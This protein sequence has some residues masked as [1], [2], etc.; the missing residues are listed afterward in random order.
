MLSL[1]R[2]KS[3]ESG[4]ISFR[5]VLET[6]PVAVMT[7]RIEDFMI[8]YVNAKSFE[9]IREIEHVLPITADQL[10]GA[11]IDV[12]HKDPSHQRMLLSNPRN[13]P[14]QAQITIGGE[15]LDLH[16]DALHDHNNNYTHAVLSW[17]VITGKV[18]TEKETRRLLQMV[19]KMPLNVMTCD[20]HDDFKINYVNQTSLDTLKKVEEYLPIKVDD[21]LGS[22]V[23][24]FHKTPSHQRNLLSNP[25]NLP[26]NAHIKVGPEVLS[27]NVSAIMDEDGSYSGPMLSWSIITDNIRMAENVSEVIEKMAET[28]N[29]MDESASQMLGLAENAQE[30][31]TGVSS[32]SEELAA[33]IKEI[34]GRINMASE[35][36]L[37]A[38]EEAKRTDAQ[39]HQL[40]ETAS[41]IGNIITVIQ[42][43]A[44]KTNLLA[45]NATIES[46]RAGEAGKGF[47]VVAA[48]VK[49]LAKQTAQSTEEIRQQIDAVQG[50]TKET[51][52][53]IQSIV[54][55]IE[56]L[57]EIAT[58]VAAAVEEQ[59]ATTAEVSQ[60]ISGVS[61]ASR[62][63]G[64]AARSVSGVTDNLR[65]YSQQLDAEVKNFLGQSGQ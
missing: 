18:K 64:E 47:A 65:E 32:A 26:H 17:S 6:L 20:I 40:N 12:F 3:E 22:S 61:D 19:D 10:L 34:S 8:D 21:L 7:C 11:C 25:A 46:A 54:K 53:S 15:I 1:I 9:L 37:S 60:N 2:Q 16:I 29:S 41:M 55:S 14:H 62:Q 30:L 45:L 35:M 38:T 27:L 51:V 59:S 5:S 48:E 52:E 39:V 23:D 42:E 57:S 4:A 50:I 36:S 63:T 56:S 43:I 24:V 58:E 13:L 31:S 49:E 28:S 33:T 44:E